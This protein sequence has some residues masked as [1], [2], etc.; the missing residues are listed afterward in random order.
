MFVADTHALVWYLTNDSRLG[1]KAKGALEKTDRGEEETIIPTV[2]LAEVL[3]MSRK[4]KV[5]F[6]R[7]LEAVES[8]RNY[9]AY[10]LGIHVI[11]EMKKLSTKYSIH[12]AAIVATAKILGAPIITKDEVIREL[13]DVKTIWS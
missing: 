9:S 3:F 11:L 1:V 4:R 2:V 13:G 8:G 10:P 5:S 6:E 12:D 7:L